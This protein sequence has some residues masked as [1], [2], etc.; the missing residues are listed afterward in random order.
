M[1]SAV[2]EVVP[3]EN[4]EFRELVESVASAYQKEL[5]ARVSVDV[6]MNSATTVYLENLE[7]AQDKRPWD[8]VFVS[9]STAKESVQLPDLKMFNNW[10][11]TAPWYFRNYF[12]KKGKPI[13]LDP[14]DP[15]SYPEDPKME[16]MKPHGRRFNSVKEA[17]AAADRENVQVVTEDIHGGKF[18]F[19]T[20]ETESLSMDANAP[21]VPTGEHRSWVKKVEQGFYPFSGD[22]DKMWLV[23]PNYE[24]RG[25]DRLTWRNFATEGDAVKA[26]MEAGHD[27]VIRRNGSNSYLIRDINPKGANGSTRINANYTS[28][29]AVGTHFDKLTT[30]TKYFVETPIIR[31]STFV[32][33][34]LASIYYLRHTSNANKEI[35][36]QSAARDRHW[37]Q[38]ASHMN[39]LERPAFYLFNGHSTNMGNLVMKI[40]VTAKDFRKPGHIAQKF[41]QAFSS[42]GLNIQVYDYS[43]WYHNVALYNRTGNVYTI[44]YNKA[45]IDASGRDN[46]Y[47]T[48]NKNTEIVETSHLGVNWWI[49]SWWNCVWMYC[50]RGLTRWKGTWSW[51]H[52]Y[53]HYDYTYGKDGLSNYNYNLA[54]INKPSDLV[55]AINTSFPGVLQAKLNYE[56]YLTTNPTVNAPWHMRNKYARRWT[57]S[58]SVRNLNREVVG[59]LINGSQ[60]FFNDKKLNQTPNIWSWYW[61][62]S[63]SNRTWR[64]VSH[65]QVQIHPGQEIRLDNID[66]TEYDGPDDTLTTTYRFTDIDQYI[67]SKDIKSNKIEQY[68]EILVG[69]F[70]DILYKLESEV[71]KAQEEHA[72]GKERF[73]IDEAHVGKVSDLVNSLALAKGAYNT[74]DTHLTDVRS[75]LYIYSNKSRKL[76]DAYEDEKIDARN[77]TKLKDSARLDRNIAFGIQIVSLIVGAGAF[78]ALVYSTMSPEIVAKN[79]Q[80]AAIAMI[81]ASIVAWFT[82]YKF[83][84]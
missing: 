44:G 54:M 55:T 82:Y 66:M 45:F 32:Q 50:H 62:W 11:G 3:L 20:L 14:N 19:K 79:L 4:S 65:P 26:A 75:D 34:I 68:R 72:K 18:F 51:W 83:Y 15:Q 13:P 29:V 38:D 9:K 5:R 56:R 41:I 81:V 16:M 35:Y 67:R 46:H 36:K 28:Y 8:S 49:W 64:Y 63:W 21:E 23:R 22:V 12:E 61:R 25:T 31:G 48:L 47:W 42:R 78:G 76:S 52:Y 24:V 77:L 57:G 2:T 7:I 1:A 43:R 33:Q 80:L 6:D 84:F 60:K 73:T 71:F 70:L 40:N 30:L 69:Y 74:P 59:L 10:Q 39:G 27:L 53:Y 17:L 37:I 58:I